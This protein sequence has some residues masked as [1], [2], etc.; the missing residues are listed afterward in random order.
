MTKHRPSIVIVGKPNVG[1][2]TLFNTILGRKEAITGNDYG[3]TRDYQEANCT[4][5][6][7][8][9]KLIDTAGYNTTK[10]DFTQKLNEITNIQINSA[11]LVLFVIDGSTSLTNEDRDFRKILQKSGKKIVLLINKSELKSAKNYNYQFNELGI[12]DFIHITALSKNSINI[13][14]NKIKSNIINSFSSKTSKEN[15]AL[16]HENIRISIVGKPNVGKSTL[17]NLLYGKERVVTASLAGT[18]RDSVMSEIN[19][20]KY[21]FELIDTAGLRKKGKVNQ[22]IEKAAA[23]YSR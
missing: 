8:E 22:N 4:I 21:I 17:Y 18:T 11:D 2:S 12:K 16:S 9:L 7:I 1:K 3:L 10:N 13:I 23:Y 15:N 5:G 19:H 14:Y 20:K 6:E